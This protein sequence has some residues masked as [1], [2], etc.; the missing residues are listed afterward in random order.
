M[1]LEILAALNA[2]RT[3]RRATV[4]IT[5]PATGAQR[6]VKESAFAS[7]PLADLLSERLRIGKSGMAETPDGEVFLA[8]Q[9]PPVRIVVTGAVHI[10]P[11][12][13]ADGAALGA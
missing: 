6:L 1:K 9:V 10:S 4:V 13:R 5:N 2:E 12:A 7:D 3:A 8:V 11:G